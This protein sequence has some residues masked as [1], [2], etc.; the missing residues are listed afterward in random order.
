MILIGGFMSNPI[1]NDVAPGK[2]TVWS[3]TVSTL[4]SCPARF[5]LKYNDS[6]ASDSLKRIAAVTT[7][8]INVNGT[9]LYSGLLKNM[10]STAWSPAIPVG[11]ALTMDITTRIS[12]AATLLRSDIGT[13]L[14]YDVHSECY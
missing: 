12:S 2:D 6:T 14:S 11:G 5:Y 4:A 3:G 10:T 9:Q 13:D 1:L 8:T 7:I